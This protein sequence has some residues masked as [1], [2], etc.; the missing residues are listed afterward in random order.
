[1][2][3]WCQDSIDINMNSKTATLI[4]L[5]AILLWSL[6]VALIKEVSTQFGAVGGAALIYT[7]A[8]IFLLL[9]VGW[10]PLKSF[11][12]TYLIWGAFFLSPMK[13]VFHFQLDIAKQIDKQLK[14]E[15]SIIYGQLSRWLRRFYLINKKQIF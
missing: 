13:F 15:W 9:S 4:G 3:L 5:L 8:S 14:L 11:P 6:I 1:M 12:K 2:L 7:L 10:T